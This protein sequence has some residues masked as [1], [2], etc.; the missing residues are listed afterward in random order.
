MLMVA[1]VLIAAEKVMS[2]AV[3][4][5]VAVVALVGIWELMAAV[6]ELCLICY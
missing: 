6:M 3:N 2:P 5:L 1:M 4:I